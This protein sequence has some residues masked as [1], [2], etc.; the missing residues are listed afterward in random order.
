MASELF[1]WQPPEGWKEWEFPP[2]EEG[3]LPPGTEAPDFELSAVDGSTIRLSDYRGNV[4][5]LNK[6]RCG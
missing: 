5:W 6:W 1:Q 4:V 2:I 3:L